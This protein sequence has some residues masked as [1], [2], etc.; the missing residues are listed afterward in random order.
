MPL[1]LRLDADTERLLNRLARRTGRTKSDVIRDAVRAWARE[2]SAPRSG[3]TVYD[4]IAHLIGCVD[5]CGLNLSTSTG[6]RFRALL[7]ERVAGRRSR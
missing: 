2:E 1:S 7:A 4:A 3:P 6:R 5:S